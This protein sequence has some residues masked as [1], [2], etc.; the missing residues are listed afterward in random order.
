MVQKW[1]ETGQRRSIVHA[2]SRTRPIVDASRPPKSVMHVGVRRR[3]PRARWGTLPV[4]GASCSGK[5]QRTQR[6]LGVVQRWTRQG[7]AYGVREDPPSTRWGQCPLRAWYSQRQQQ[8]PNER[9]DKTGVGVP[10]VC[11]SEATPL[12]MLPGPIL[13]K[14]SMGAG[15]RPALHGGRLLFAKNLYAFKYGFSFIF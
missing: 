14:S 5:A 8:Y 15:F 11:K 7:D 4:V 12:P 2:C 9:R 13:W 1:D 6:M 10:Y 3:P